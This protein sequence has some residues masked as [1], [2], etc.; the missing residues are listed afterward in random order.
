MY[1]KQETTFDHLVVGGKVETENLLAA[2]DIK[3][4]DV[5][6]SYGVCTSATKAKLAVV[7]TDDVS[8]A[9]PQAGKLVHS[10]VRP[11][12]TEPAGAGLRR[13]PC[14]REENFRFSRRCFL[15]NC[16]SLCF[17]HSG[18][19][20]ARSPLWVF[21]RPLREILTQ[22]LTAANKGQQGR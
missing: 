1:E 15:S 12:P 17:P 18:A 19:N 4:G 21:P 5:V 2:A 3:K 6:A 16:P 10:V 11:L 13:E 8:L 22:R 7:R 14:V 9:S 20:S